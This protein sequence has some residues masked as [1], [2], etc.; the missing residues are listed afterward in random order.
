MVTISVSAGTSHQ[1]LPATFNSV[2]QA[3]LAPNMSSVSTATQA[4]KLEQG[5]H[6]SALITVDTSPTVLDKSE[7][8]PSGSPARTSRRTLLP[9]ITEEVAPT[10]PQPFTFF[11]EHRTE[12]AHPSTSL[13]VEPSG[14]T[15]LPPGP[16][17]FD[18]GSDSSSSASSTS[19]SCAQVLPALMLTQAVRQGLPVALL[20]GERWSF[21]L[22][23]HKLANSSA[24]LCLKSLFCPGQILSTNNAP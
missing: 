21:H 17:L 16:S 5:S 1:Q 8:P 7:P 20:S 2:N 22:C 23:L 24:S 9:K 11:S 3:H 12:P 18:S 4:A 10:S 15:G 19:P 6:S 14:L 13:L